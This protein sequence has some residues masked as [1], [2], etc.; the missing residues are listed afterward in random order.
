MTQ[1]IQNGSFDMKRGLR[2][3]KIIG[4]TKWAISRSIS[5]YK[6]GGGYMG[7]QFSELIFLMNSR[8][9]ELILLIDIVGFQSWNIFNDIVG[10]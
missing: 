10:F 6:R 4:A 5:S 1:N 3:L 8:F 9:S 7:A 2:I